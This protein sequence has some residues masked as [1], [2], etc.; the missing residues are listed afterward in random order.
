LFG[1]VLELNADRSSGVVVGAQ[2]GVK[3]IRIF[4]NS[5]DQGQD[6]PIGWLVKIMGID[7]KR[8]TDSSC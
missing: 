7:D 8:D 1:R 5:D 4:L 3:D 2:Q 6:G